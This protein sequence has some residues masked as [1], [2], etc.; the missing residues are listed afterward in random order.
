M[1]F[2]LSPVMLV[3]TEL[4]H[5]DRGYVTL[6]SPHY[7]WWTQH[8]GFYCGPPNTTPAALYSAHEF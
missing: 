3:H 2:H 5:C 6:M 4:I 7:I 8:I 1:A